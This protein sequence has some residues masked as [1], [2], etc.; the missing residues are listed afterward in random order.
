MENKVKLD[1]CNIE[2]VEK[3]LDIFITTYNR[4][5]KLAKTLDYFANSPFRT[6]SITI[7]NNA[8]TDDTLDMINSKK[9]LFADLKVITHPINIGGD[10]N[11]I[12]TVEYCTKEYMWIVHDDDN[13]DFSDCQ[14]LMQ[15][16]CEGKVGLIHVGAHVEPIRN[17][18]SGKLGNIKDFMS[19]GYPYFK[20]SSFTPC[21][22]FKYQE[23]IP[24]VRAGHENIHN[25]Y[26]IMPFLISK[27]ENNDLLYI[28][29]KQICKASVGVQ[30]YDD[31]FL[32]K[33]WFGTSFLFK[34]NQDRR[35]Y[36]CEQFSS[37]SSL[38]HTTLN[39]FYQSFQCGSLQI[40]KMFYAYLNIG[41]K[42]LCVLLCFPYA[43]AK[44]TKQLY[45]KK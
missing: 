11:I 32:V 6:C 14:D 16:L 38:L 40:F 4:S 17:K 35:S 27:F 31:E 43:F 23:I 29:K 42:I 24:F 36:F 18:F 44:W 19:C 1:K 2:K 8:S 33:S 13:F 41:E 22:I 9:Q 34:N 39:R 20:F 26:A 25:H 7:F 5:D 30:S 10:A 21:N 45:S 15:I 28:T 3:I 37:N 12:R